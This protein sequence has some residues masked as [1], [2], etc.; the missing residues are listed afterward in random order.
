MAQTFFHGGQHMRVAAGLDEDDPVGM[1][2]GEMEGGREQIAPAQAPEYRAVE[3]GE[4]AGEEDRRGGIVGQV[5]ATR[6]LMQRAGSYPAAGQ[7]R[8]DVGYAEGEGGMTNAHALDLRDMRTQMIEDG[9]FG[10]GVTRLRRR[11]IVP[12][13]FGL[14]EVES[15]AGRRNLCSIYVLC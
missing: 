14:I 15:Q 11:G 13:L 7:M 12:S 5:A 2:A 8:V 1:E 4:N 3:A 9:R 10:H 6:H